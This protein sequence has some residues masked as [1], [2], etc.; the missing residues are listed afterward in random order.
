M[1][2]SLKLKKEHEIKNDV[3]KL[4][5]KFLKIKVLL[6]NELMQGRKPA[7]Y[8]VKDART[9]QNYFSDFEISILRKIGDVKYLISLANS[10]KLEDKISNSLL[11]SLMPAAQNTA[12]SFSK[13]QIKRF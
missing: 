4:A 13:Q 12:L 8:E 3:Q 1:S 6:E 11:I 9:K 5:D 2:K 10:H 7:F